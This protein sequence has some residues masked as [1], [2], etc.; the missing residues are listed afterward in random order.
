MNKIE[1]PA[2]L[3]APIEDIHNSEKAYFDLKA[4]NDLEEFEK[5]DGLIDPADHQT[6]L[7]MWGL[8][9]LKDKKILECACGSGFF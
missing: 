5:G 1:R 8:N 4:K 9:D 7:K 6:T 3:A 2:G